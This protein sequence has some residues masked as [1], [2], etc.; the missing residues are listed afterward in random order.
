MPS[1]RTW[2][3]AGGAAAV[4]VVGVVAGPL[5][6]AAIEDDAP[7]APT[8]QAQESVAPLTTGA[9]GATALDGSWAVGPG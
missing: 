5:V 9:D 2:T 4:L 1:R 8:V 6:Y 7:P 3:I